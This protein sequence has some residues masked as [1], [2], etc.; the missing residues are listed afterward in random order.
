MSRLKLQSLEY[1]RL[2]AYL[3]WCYKIVFNVVDICMDEFF[4][5]NTCTYT[6]GHACKLYKSRPLTSIRK[7]FFSERVINAVSYTHL[8]LPTI[9]RV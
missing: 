4:C 5:F 2:I 9:L 8:T 7:N 3:L 6:R 1:R